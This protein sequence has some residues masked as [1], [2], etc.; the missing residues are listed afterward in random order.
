MLPD[1]LFDKSNANANVFSN[2]CYMK[3]DVSKKDWFFILLVILFCT[4]HLLILH[5]MG[6]LT[7]SVQQWGLPIALPF[8]TSIV[9]TFFLIAFV[10]LFAIPGKDFPNDNNDDLKQVIFCIII[11][12]ILG[13]VW[14]TSDRSL[15]IAIAGAVSIFSISLFK[16]RNPATVLASLIIGAVAIPLFGFQFWRPNLVIYN[17]VLFTFLLLQ[18]LFGKEEKVT[19]H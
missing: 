9:I 3:L 13:A 8:W 1:L 10:F 19:R 12:T 5:R 6:Y 4:A 16:G 7:L 18:I 15:S 17:L 11:G 2:T 14:W